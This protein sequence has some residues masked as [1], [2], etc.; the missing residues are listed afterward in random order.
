MPAQQWQTAHSACSWCSYAQRC[1]YIGH[2]LGRCWRNSRYSL[3]LPN[4]RRTPARMPRSSWSSIFRLF[5]T[6]PVV[7][8]KSPPHLRRHPRILVS[9][10]RSLSLRAIIPPVLSPAHGSISGARWP[11]THAPIE[12][13]F[14]PTGMGQLRCEQKS[15]PDGPIPPGRRAAVSRCHPA[16]HDDVQKPARAAPTTAIAG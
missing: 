3:S 15:R 14:T 13:F 2:S 12:S 6:I 4:S 5:E 7:S 16:P 11:G 8:S 10:S 9:T 1:P